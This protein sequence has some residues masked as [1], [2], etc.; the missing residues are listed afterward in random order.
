MIFISFFLIITI[1]SKKNVQKDEKSESEFSSKKKFKKSARHR[2]NKSSRKD[3]DE[4]T[5]KSS[6]IAKKNIIENKNK[7]LSKGLIV[8]RQSDYPAMNEDLSLSTWNEINYLIRN[9]YKEIKNLI[10]VLLVR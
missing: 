5:L 6:K 1:C 4:D 7:K 10:L 9:V 2:Y 3:Q 8:R